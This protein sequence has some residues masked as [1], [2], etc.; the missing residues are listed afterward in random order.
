MTVTLEEL[1]RQRADDIA[2]LIDAQVPLSSGDF[3][4][5]EVPLPA[6]ALLACSAR[7]LAWLQGDGTI[8]LVHKQTT[9]T[10]AVPHAITG[11][12]TPFEPS[13][14]TVMYTARYFLATRALS[15]PLSPRDTY[16]IYGAATCQ[17]LP[18]A[19]RTLGGEDATPSGITPGVAVTSPG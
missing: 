12:V 3:D 4:D 10:I 16:V 7:E 13:M 15:G 9:R 17:T 11:V 18:V 1:L 19:L 2:A 14:L 5:P 8:A 6:V